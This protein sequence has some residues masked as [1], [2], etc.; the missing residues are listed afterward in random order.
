[1]LDNNIFG[2]FEIRD[3]KRKAYFDL[4]LILSLS[5]VGDMTAF[6]SPM[7]KIN[8]GRLL[9]CKNSSVPLFNSDSSMIQVKRLKHFFCPMRDKISVFSIIRGAQM[10][11]LERNITY[12]RVQL[13]C[14][15]MTF[16]SRKTPMLIYEK[17]NNA[18]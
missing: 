17:T 2:L 14:Y 13:L 11:N 12:V 10:Y 1:M 7:M 3:R 5:Y 15:C 9:L 6:S 16:A 8:T 18:K 4:I